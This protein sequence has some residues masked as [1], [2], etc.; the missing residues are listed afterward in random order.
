VAQVPIGASIGKFEAQSATVLANKA[1]S[2]EYEIKQF[3]DFT[4]L[5][6][7]FNCITSFPLAEGVATLTSG[8]LQFKDEGSMSEFKT[9]VYGLGVNR[10]TQN[11]IRSM[12]SG[13]INYIPTQ[14]FQL[15]TI[16][17][18]TSDAAVFRTTS[19]S[20]N[21]VEMF[22]IVFPKHSND[23]TVF[24]N[25]MIKNFQCQI[26]GGTRYPEEKM[27]TLS[28][29]LVKMVTTI[30]EISPL[31]PSKDLLA[32]CIISRN[33]DTGAVIQ[34][35]RYSCSDFSIPIDLQRNNNEG[36]LDGYI[37]PIGLMAVQV[38]YEPIYTRDQT[39]Y[40]KVEDFRGELNRHPVS[41]QIWFCR[42]AHWE[43]KPSKY[44]ERKFEVEFITKVL[45][46][47]TD[48]GGS[49]Y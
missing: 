9:I 39:S 46:P 17:N 38:E 11:A 34:N 15:E 41:P 28:P 26:D 13:V 12:Y 6:N 42:N 37:N 40:H 19:I 32:S 8:S 18:V 35:V 49:E 10:T 2:L 48:F 44:D 14:Q 45:I 30:A 33:T 22:D 16:D 3:K 36:V 29:K 31:I 1:A 21:L 23:Y 25:P 7:T 20:V 47:G 5:P 27:T 24:E 43:I 4:Q